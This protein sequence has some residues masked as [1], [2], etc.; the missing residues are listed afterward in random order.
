MRVHRVVG[1]RFPSFLTCATVLALL[2]LGANALPAQ[3]PDSA[4]V[5]QREVFAQGPA[6]QSAPRCMAL[7]EAAL[8]PFL[9]LLAA[10]WFPS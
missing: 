2:V 8:R 10:S 1:D 9:L 6:G 4:A 3:A 7:N 5:R